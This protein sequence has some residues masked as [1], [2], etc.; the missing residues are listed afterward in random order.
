MTPRRPAISVPDC[1]IW[2]F[3]A[4]G[5]RVEISSRDA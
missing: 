4:S 2:S 5:R 3:P 1:T